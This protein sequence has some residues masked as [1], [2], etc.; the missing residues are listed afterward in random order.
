VGRDFNTEGGV[1]GGKVG[2]TM[3]SRLKQLR[4]RAGLTQQGLAVA[5]GLSMSQVT[6]MEY[7]VRTDPKLSTLLALTRALGCD[8]NELAG[9]LEVEPETPAKKRGQK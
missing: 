5:A 7:G 8:L 3:G 1:M 9:G 4:N 2:E 6:A